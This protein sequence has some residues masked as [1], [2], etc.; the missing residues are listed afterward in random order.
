MENELGLRKFLEDRGHTYI[1]TDDKEGEN[2]ELDKH[3]PDA[4]IVRPP[5]RPARGLTL[6]GHMLCL[7]CTLPHKHETLCI[8]ICMAGLRDTLTPFMH[9]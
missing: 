4:D 3:L 6:S 8:A 7:L 1:V 9:A 2:S 5:R